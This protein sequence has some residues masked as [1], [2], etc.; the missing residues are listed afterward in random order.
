MFHVIVADSHAVRV[1]E[2]NSSGAAL[3]ELVVFHNRSANQH[4]RD[5]VTA[6][7]GRVINRAAGI[8]QSFEPK[9]SAK[10]YL[11]LRWLKVTSLQLQAFLAARG[12]EAV[13]LVAAPRL[14]AEL[15]RH[16]PGGV[17]ALIRAELARDLMHQPIIALQKRLQPSVREAAR[18]VL[19]SRPVYRRLSARSR[20]PRILSPTA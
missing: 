2:T 1:F 7:P 18:S 6:R 3:E 11:T 14:L 19:R 9:V 4:E 5:L 15:R 12:S 20:R 17:R 10:Q 8:R 13:I 16:L